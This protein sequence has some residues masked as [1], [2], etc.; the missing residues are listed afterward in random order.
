MREGPCSG[1]SLGGTSHCARLDHNRQ[2]RRRHRTGMDHR[3]SGRGRRVDCR[4]LVDRQQPEHG[5]HRRCLCEWAC[6]IR[7]PA[8]G[9]AGGAVLVDDNNRVHKGDLLVQFDKEPYQ[10]QVNIAQAAVAA[11][12]ADLVAAL[13]Q[14]P[15]RSKGRCAACDLR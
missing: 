2:S 3:R 11:A 4:R 12:Q 8:C 14:V 6:D 10:V 13:A 7:R 5:F 1:H 9:R 15:R